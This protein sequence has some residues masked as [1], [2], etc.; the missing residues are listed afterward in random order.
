MHSL[1]IN[2]R[3]RPRAAMTLVELSMGLVVTS[4]VMA[5]LAS[6]WFAVARTWNSSSAQSA[7]LGGNLAAIRMENAI[8][9]AKYLIQYRAGSVDGA[10]SP[11]ARLFYWAADNWPSARDEAPQLAELALIEHDAVGKRLYLYQ[12]IPWASMSTDQRNRAGG[13][14][15]WTELSQTGTAD[16]FKTYDFVTK[17]V[18]A[19]GV[20]GAMFYVPPESSTTRQMLEHAITTQRGNQNSVEYGTASLR[21]PTTKPS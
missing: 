14:P 10:A 13:V 3:R 5:A 15:S 11:T 4:M 21:S 2:P 18:F 12:A 16:T 8:R 17:T 7:S 19:E 20:A 9:Q 1:P 6:F